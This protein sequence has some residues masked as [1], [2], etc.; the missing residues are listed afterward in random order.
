MLKK[1]R[2]SLTG[3]RSLIVALTALLIML[4]LYFSAPDVFEAV[5]LRL[6]EWRFRLRGPQNPGALVKLILVDTAERRR[7]G[8]DGEF[9]ARLADVLD[10]LCAGGARVVGIDLFFTGNSTPGNDGATQA[11]SE[12]VQRC[13]NV[14]MGYNWDYVAQPSRLGSA[15]AIGRRRLLDATRNPD[16]PGF[17]PEI[18]PGQARVADPA[19]IRR[20]V[21]VGYFTTIADGKRRAYKVP[22]TQAFQRSL[23]FP[24]SL[25]VVRTYLRQRGYGLVSEPGAG[26]LSGPTLGNLKLRPDPRGY[27]W[28]NFYGPASVF[29]HLSFTEAMEEGVPTDFARGAIVLIGVSGDDSGDLFDT[30]YDSNTPGLVLHATAV[31]NALSNRFLTRDLTVR[32]IELSLLVAI[33]LL[34]GVLVPRLPPWMAIL[35]GPAIMLG[36]ALLSGLLLYRSNIWLQ[37]ICPLLEA[38]TLHLGL[39]S[40]RISRAEYCCRINENK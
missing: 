31:A 4:A 8:L 27:L 26:T 5:E 12:A 24:F 33:A 39:L 32:G 25:A 36:V 14:V 21:A 23:L 2:V 10:K 37:L 3:K 13:G 38:F 34:L 18:I 35:L 15:E 30:P 19:L 9:R 7:Y 22:A 28:L 40:V 16:E 20:A 1:E 29:P 11:L 17:T 6:L